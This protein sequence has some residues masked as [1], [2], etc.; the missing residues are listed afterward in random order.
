MGTL[1]LR[2]LLTLIPT[3]L[4]VSFGVYGLITLIPGDAAV[5]L[6]GGINATPEKVEEVREQLGLD[7]PFITQY[8]NWLKDAVTGD[9]GQS[10]TTGKS[11]TS[12]IRQA[13]PVTLSIV[14]AGLA[15]G[16]IFGI[17]AGILAGMRPGS[18]LDRGLISATTLSNAIPSFFLAM[19]LI[20][21][22]A[23]NLK[24]F[25]ALGFT[26]ITDDPVQWLKAVT[27]PAIGIG[28]GVAGTQ[29]RQVRAALADVM[30][31]AYVRTAWSMG[32]DTRTVVT[33]H[34]LKNAAIPA[35]T[36]IGLQLGGLLGGA[37]LVEQ[38]FSIPGLGTY[39][40]Q[41]IYAFNLPVIQGVAL[42]FVIINVMISLIIDISYGFLDP[43][44]RVS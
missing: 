3:M 8:W 15:F 24:W 4:I 41:A 37:V 1:I 20:T 28:L 25:P 30:G 7:D 40:L 12:E 36:V 10:L 16:L 23:I 43:R 2:R 38:I 44:V 22:F 35:I 18:R 21:V 33:K 31:S 6:A 17:P 13:F 9:L 34:A 27:L 14:A 32:A 39:I 11:V 29:A 26:R 5:Q 19:L 42:M